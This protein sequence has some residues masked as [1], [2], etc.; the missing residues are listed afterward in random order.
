MRLLSC[1]RM[2]C[3]AACGQAASPP[4]R[5]GLSP[6]RLHCRMPRER[7]SPTG[8]IRASVRSTAAVCR[9][10]AT[11]I[12]RLFNSYSRKKTCSIPAHHSPCA[13][14]LKDFCIGPQIDHHSCVTGSAAIAALSASKSAPFVSATRGA[15]SNA[16]TPPAMR[17][18]A[19][20]LNRRSRAGGD[21]IANV[22]PDRQIRSAVSIAC[23]LGQLSLS[24][25]CRAAE[26]SRQ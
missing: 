10:S 11:G 3:I 26:V 14:D 15:R 8:R 1:L 24:N 18:A 6:D 13:R 23:I 17:R 4:S 2:G 9:R 25:I 20:A 22:M 19:R 5:V 7:A 16:T 12:T 21:R